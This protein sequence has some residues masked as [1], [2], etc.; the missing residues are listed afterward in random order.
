MELKG[1]VALVTGASGGIGRES[2]LDFAR[3]GADVV[4]INRR[5]KEGVQTVNM[6]KELG[7]RAFFLK[8]DVANEGECRGMVDEALSK[9]GRLDFAFNNAGIEGEFGPV[10]GQS[11]ENFRKVIDINVLGVML[12]MK[13]E[14]PAIRKSGGGAIVNNASIAGTI[15]MPNGAVYIAS[16][17]AVIGMTRCAAL[18]VAKEK[19]R[20]NCVSPGAIQTEMWER[21][22]D[23]DQSK[24]EYMIGLHPVGRVG[25]PFEIASAVT[26]LCSPGASFITGTNLVI[27]GG[28]TAQ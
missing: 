11:V 25:T 9:F 14:I 5:E 19:I 18:E 27:D 12:S 7:R 1:K 13:Y 22:T 3:H 16:K 10:E 26:Y 4:V 23:F 8:A 6:I 15:G 20:I 2:A 17:H 28:F 21:F 24:Q